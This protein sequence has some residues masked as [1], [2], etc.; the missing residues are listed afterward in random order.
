[1]ARLRSLKALEHVGFAK[2][3]MTYIRNFGKKSL[4][5]GELMVSFQIRRAYDVVI[6]NSEKKFRLLV[7]SE[8]IRTSRL[9]EYK[10]VKTIKTSGSHR[11]ENREPLD[12]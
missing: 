7:G 6:L 8:G 10:E 4:C 2:E 1:M 5:D 11:D 9:S 12:I 3:R